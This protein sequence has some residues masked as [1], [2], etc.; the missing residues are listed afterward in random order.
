M[1]LPSL[2]PPPGAATTALCGVG[3]YG[4]GPF[5]WQTPLLLDDAIGASLQLS[6]DQMLTSQSAIF[7][8]WAAGAVVLGGAADVIGRKPVCVFSGLLIALELAGCS[9]ADSFS[10]LL[11]SR[12]V[13]GFALGGT[14]SG[15]TLA[16]ESASVEKQADVGLALNVG[17]SGAVV[18]LL[19]LHQAVGGAMHLSWHDELV[20]YA[21]TVAA[22][23]GA[24]AMC[25]PE[26]PAFLAAA[27]AAGGAEGAGP[28]T[29]A[30]GTLCSPA[31]LPATL[32]LVFCFV[33]ATI[34]YFSLSFAAGSLGGTGLET[35]ILLL[36]LLDLP[37]PYLAA[38]LGER[39]GASAPST[40]ALLFCACS[41]LLA[42]LAATASAADGGGPSVVALALLGKLFLNGAFQCVYLLPMHSFPPCARTTGLGLANSAARLAAVAVPS[43]ASE[44]GIGELGVG[45]AALGVGAAAV[46]T[47]MRPWEE[48]EEEAV[49]GGRGRGTLVS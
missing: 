45:C 37:G 34:V 23:V 42:A 4:A 5:V 30:I 19:A 44:L 28:R 24:T 33:V 27:A 10:G 46:V 31:Y 2:R 26:S 16:V 14:A 13:G 1:R 8:A 21:A 15:F 3:I 17:F 47:Q 6:H 39:E 11:A 7:L 36:A 32:A 29:D 35:N 20:A 38:R 48:L 18:L 49:K 43:A 22:L 25:V 9:C 40:A 41:G 12:L